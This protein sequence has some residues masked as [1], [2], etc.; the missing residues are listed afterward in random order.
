MIVAGRFHEDDDVD[1][2]WIQH[3]VYNEALGI[4][5]GICQEYT[6]LAHR[7]LDDDL[8]KW[9]IIN[10]YDHRSMQRAHDTIAAAWRL[11][12][13]PSLRQMEFPL[14]GEP[15]EWP[16]FAGHW[17]KWLEEEVSSWK[18]HT[19]LIRLVVK[20]VQNQSV[21]VGYRAEDDLNVELL[22][23][24]EDVPWYQSVVDAVYSIRQAELT[25]QSEATGG[26]CPSRL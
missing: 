20:I 8:P 13:L 24:Y 3:D 4:I 17:L 14:D 16:D 10:S 1:V 25:K 21:P 23:H 9:E 5:S 18:H 19:P 6:N 26:S 2:M 11:R 7:I 12:C 22:L 15:G